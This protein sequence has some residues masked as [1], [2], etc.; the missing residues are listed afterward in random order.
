MSWQEFKTL[1]IGISP[2]T[3]LGKIV[4]IRAEDDKDVLK[5]FTSDQKRI[6]TEWRTKHARK[7]DRKDVQAAMTEFEKNFLA[8]IGV[9]YNAE[10]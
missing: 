7:M 1:L 4:S 10:N 9:N 2:D 8:M 3:V 5:N 6:R